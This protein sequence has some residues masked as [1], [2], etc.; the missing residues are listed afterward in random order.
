MNKPEI[1][2]EVYEQYLDATVALFMEHYSAMLTEKV[3]SEDKGGEV[4]FPE[5]LD[6]KCKALIKKEASKQKRLTLCKHIKRT[7]KAAAVFAVAVL[8]TFSMLFVSV[9]AFRV[10][11]VNFYV[12]HGDGYWS[13]NSDQEILQTEKESPVD[14][15]DINHPL[16]GLISD[17]YVLVD[18]FNADKQQISAT[19]EN[20]NNDRIRFAMLPY[21]SSIHIDTENADQAREL[22]IL[23]YSA[24]L[25]TKNNS[26]QLAWG[27]EENDTMYLLA[28]DNVK[29]SD[30]IMIAE[31]LIKMIRK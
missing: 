22:D 28:A 21:N 9:E 3:S 12:E 7:L 29:E 30:V 27:D 14:N 23:G 10:G 5:T 24:V 15:F 31:E 11:V 8:T 17:D 6:L 4:A 16:K 1:N 18:I 2:Q 26:T 13:I 19:Y 25:A 20:S